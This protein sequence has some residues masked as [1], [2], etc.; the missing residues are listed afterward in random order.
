MPRP[1]ARAR[2]RPRRAARAPP[3]SDRPPATRP[4]SPRRRR[5]RRRSR[6]AALPSSMPA[7]APDRHLRRALADHGGDG[8]QARRRRSADRDCPSTWSRTRR[9]CRHS[10]AVRAA[11]PRA[12]SSVLIDSP[13]IGVAPEQ[14]PRDLDRAYRPADMHAVGLSRERDIDTVVDQQRHTVRRE[15]RPDRARASSIMRRVLPSC[16][17]TGQASRRLRDQRR[18]S[19][20]RSR[21]SARSGSTIA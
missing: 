10:R 17:A 2:H 16:R 5:R 1:V 6:R 20:A 3:L 8:A 7:M 12:C 21:P 11:Q 9:R 14:Q 15:R 13:M 4:R 18:A 19:S